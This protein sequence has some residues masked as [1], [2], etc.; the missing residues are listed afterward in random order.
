MELRS[1]AKHVS[2]YENG[3]AL[4]KERQRGSPFATTDSLFREKE[5]DPRSRR[6]RLEDY[7]LRRRESLK[8]RIEERERK[9]GERLQ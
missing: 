7:E 1:A 3:N 8:R 2:D 4:T 9:A 5:A 6:L